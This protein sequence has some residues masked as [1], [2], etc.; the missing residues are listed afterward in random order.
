MQVLL[1]LWLL[2]MGMKDVTWDGGLDRE[3]PAPSSGTIDVVANEGPV[4]PPKP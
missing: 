2:V 4:P 3:A 1:V